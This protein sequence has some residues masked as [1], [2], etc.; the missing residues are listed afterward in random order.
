MPK[1]TE[2]LNVVVRKWLEVILKSRKVILSSVIF[3][4]N[5]GKLCSSMSY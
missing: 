2:L 4:T 1:M 3:E 5:N